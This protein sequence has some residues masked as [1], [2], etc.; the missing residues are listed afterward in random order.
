MS[1]EDVKRKLTSLREWLD[2]QI[3]RRPRLIITLY[4]IA[5]T[6]IAIVA[7]DT[8]QK[9][10]D[11]EAGHKQSLAIR[12]HGRASEPLITLNFRGDYSAPAAV[13][14]GVERAIADLDRVSCGLAKVNI[15]W[16]YNR[17]WDLPRAALRGDN[18]IQ[19][20]SVLD[21]E[22]SLGRDDADDLLGMT[23][24]AKNPRW[25]PVW[26]FLVNDRLEEDSQLAEWTALHE[27]GHALGMNHVKNG[28]MEPQAPYFFGLEDTP[29]WS[30]EDQNEFC[31]IYRCDPEAFIRCE[32]K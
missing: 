7:Y 13:H 28:L 31:R 4:V 23:R 3:T 25:N 1:W 22:T 18:V 26:I 29:E 16:D 30:V 2:E 5:F 21:V 32:A 8:R 27:L 19:G 6:I 20:V 12:Q 10:V 17:E 11:S 24:S 9:I 14:R 15:T